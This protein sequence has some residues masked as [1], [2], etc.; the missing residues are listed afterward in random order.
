M[1]NCFVNVY[2]IKCYLDDMKKVMFSLC[3]REEVFIF[4]FGG[5]GYSLLSLLNENI[6]VCVDILSIFSIIL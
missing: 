1:Y 3:N 2:K 5:G 6:H 4:F